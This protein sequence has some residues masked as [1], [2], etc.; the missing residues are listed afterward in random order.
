MAITRITDIIVPEVFYGYVQEQATAKNRLLMSG[1]VASDP[2][3]NTGLSGGGLTFQVR[4]WD[5][6][7]N[8]STDYNVSSDNPNSSATPD[9]VTTNK[10][11]ATRLARNA[12]WSSSDLAAE[13]NGADPM[14]VVAAQVGTYQNTQRQKTML[15]ILTGVVDSSPSSFE[16]DISATS[17]GSVTDSTSVNADTIIDTL[18]GFDDDQGTGHVLV[19]HG[20][21]YRSLQKKNLITFEPTNAQNLGWGTYLGMS[22]VVDSAVYKGNAGTGAN[23][24]V[25]YIFKPGAVG[26]GSAM[27]RV[28]VEV[29][30]EALQGDGGGV[31]T[32]VVR[33]TF[34][35][36][37][38]GM[39]W[40]GT[41]A[42]ATPT[43]T[44]LENGANWTLAFNRK[45]IGIAALRSNVN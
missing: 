2:S 41:P 43:N 37:P 7:S 14:G 25:T 13:L 30:R 26:F 40:T 4:G 38:Y 44:E 29:E 1:A 23:E 19:M 15:S 6:I 3:L 24:Y 18:S 21:V 9:K 31:E 17:T 20:D 16:N 35:F 28:P 10:Q 33:D 42:G 11:I 36:H 34:A 22:V 32:M 12:A 8:T 39:A 45:N 27:P 5:H